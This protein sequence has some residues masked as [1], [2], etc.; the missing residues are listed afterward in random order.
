MDRLIELHKKHEATNIPAVVEAAWLHHRFTQI[1]PF[2]DGNGRVARAIASLVLIRAG[3]F[4]LVINRDA[5]DQYIDA[6]EKADAGD[7]APLSAMIAQ[8]QKQALTQ[9][10]RLIADV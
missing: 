8:N 9:V 3:L 6:L 10:M 1:H 5:R 2:Q 7:L 4:P